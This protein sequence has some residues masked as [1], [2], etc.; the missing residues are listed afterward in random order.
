M[1]KIKD[2]Y[3]GI[4]HLFDN[5]IDKKTERHLAISESEKRE[6]GSRLVQLHLG[7]QRLE[8]GMKVELLSLILLLFQQN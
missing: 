7:I 2:D 6:I 3:A 1:K 4:E 5:E 8:D